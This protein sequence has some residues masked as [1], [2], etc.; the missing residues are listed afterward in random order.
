MSQRN[1]VEAAH[2]EHI[3]KLRIIHLKAGG[4]IGRGF[5]HH[6]VGNSTNEKPGST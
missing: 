5:G 3:Q 2:T 4:D 6:M 1:E